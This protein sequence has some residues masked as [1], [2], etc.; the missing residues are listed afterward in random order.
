MSIPPTSI[1]TSTTDI[2][3]ITTL[4]TMPLVT[5]TSTNNPSLSVSITDLIAEHDRPYADYGHL[6]KL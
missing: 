3:D 6:S 1:N 5:S 4:L 2:D